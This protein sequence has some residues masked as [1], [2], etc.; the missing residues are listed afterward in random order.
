M[1]E[2]K[3]LQD[4]NISLIKEIENL[5]RKIQIVSIWMQREVTNQA[6]KI[7]RNKTKDFSSDIREDFLKENFE[8]VIAQRIYDYFWDILLLNAPKWTIE[9]ITSAEINYYNMMKNPSIDGFA[10]IAAY[11]KVL[12]LFIESFI[13]N[14]Y[15][16]Y[17]RK[18]K[19][20]ILRVN[21]HLEKT[22]NFVVNR[23]YILSVGR[24]YGILKTIK[25]WWE[26]FDYWNNFKQFLEKYYELS[27]ILLDDKFLS[28]YWELNNL[29]IFGSKR[30]S[31]SISKEET[32][33]ARG[34]LI[35]NFEDK[36][37]LIYRL[38]ESQSVMF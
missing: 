1:D 21:D 27:D 7:A 2:L 37:S 28:Q 16:K 29:W 35:W 34:I 17:A 38:L 19:Q 13:I 15:R 30:H 33:Q 26:L 6:K 22:L 36:S 31:W 5:N 9:A 11:H 8:D 25:Y 24:L 12:D 23:W 3:K 18:S 14:W 32:I 10:V 20:T 4:E